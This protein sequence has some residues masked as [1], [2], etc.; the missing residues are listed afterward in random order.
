MPEPAFPTLGRLGET[1]DHPAV[2]SV[3]GRRDQRPLSVWMDWKP[4]DPIRRVFSWM[5]WQALSVT[6]VLPSRAR[7]FMSL[8]KDCNPKTSPRFWP[9][10]RAPSAKTVPRRFPKMPRG[11][12]T[13]W[14]VLLAVVC[15]ALLQF[16]N[17]KTPMKGLATSE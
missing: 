5:E 7:P 17:R 1:F 11:R 9:S 12:A 4:A 8:L 2:E 14:G 16:S 6:T 13:L 10:K 3:A 15:L